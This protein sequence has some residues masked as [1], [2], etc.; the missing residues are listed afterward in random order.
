[1]NRIKKRTTS[2]WLV[3]IRPRLAGFEVTGD[4]IRLAVA[5]RLLCALCG[6]DAFRLRLK[7][8][9]FGWRYVGR[10]GVGLPIAVL[11]YF[12]KTAS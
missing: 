2:E 6:T 3:L 10:S 8:R 5:P 11:V 4:R 9:A 12:L 1:M 7:P